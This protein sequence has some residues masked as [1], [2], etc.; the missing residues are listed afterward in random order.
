MY[1][2]GIDLAWSTRNPSGLTILKLEKNKLSI[3]YADS[4]LSDNEI[5]S[6]IQNHIPNNKPC[7][8]G[9]DAPIVVKNELG[10]RIAEKLLNKDFK[11][12]NACAHPSNRTRLS[13]WTGNIRGEE[14]AKKLNSTNFKHK[15]LKKSKEDIRS[16]YEVFPH[17]ACIVLFKLNSILKYKAKKNREL[18]LRQKELEK[19]YQYIKKNFKINLDILGKIEFSELKGKQ[20]KK[21]EDILDSIVCAFIVYYYWCDISKTKIY[22]NLKEGYILTPKL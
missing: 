20:F 16:Y 18:K 14:I 7:L 8:I 22:G 17:S 13:S 5:I 3:L 21:T 12:Y 2:V 4:I 9:I 6:I 1:F 11:K 10:Q 19:L 15:F